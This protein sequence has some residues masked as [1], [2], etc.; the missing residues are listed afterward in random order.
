MPY[1]PSPYAVVRKMLELASPV[2]G[3]SVYDLGAGDGRILLEAV[4]RYDVKAVGFEH[5][6]KRVRLATTNL[7]RARVLDKAKVFKEDL[8]KA[9]L[10]QASVVTLY[11]LPEMNRAL[12]PKLLTELK[13]GSRI[14]CHDFPIPRLSPKRVEKVHLT[15]RVHYVYLYEL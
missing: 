14:V 6:P 15:S 13:P 7:E 5:N 12:L 11:L 10:T 9:D 1:V 4:R 3:E 8:F 2:S